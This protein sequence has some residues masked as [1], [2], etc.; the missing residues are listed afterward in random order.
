M[1]FELKLDTPDKIAM[2]YFLFGM[3]IIGCIWWGVTNWA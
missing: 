1:A 3:F 2:Y